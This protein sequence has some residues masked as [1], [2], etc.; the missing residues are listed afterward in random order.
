LQLIYEPF[1]LSGQWPTFQ[2]VNAVGWH[3]L[4]SPDG[5]PLEPRLVYYELSG[6]GLV[7]PPVQRDRTWELRD[8][9]VVSLSLLGLTYLDAASA[10]VGNCVNAVR[11]IGERAH[12]FRPASPT[13]PERLQI[14]SE[15]IRLTLR[16]EVG[17]R[18]LLR[19]A[20]LLQQD[21]SGVWTSFSGPDPGAGWSFTVD[22]D[23]AR[24]YRNVATAYDVLDVQH[25][26]RQA[27]APT[28]VQYGSLKAG[29]LEE[30]TMAVNG[31]RDPRV[32]ISYSHRDQEFVLA[33]MEELKRRGVRVW[34]DQ[35]E[36]VVGDSLVTRIGDA[37][38][39]GDFVVGVI[40]PHSVESSWCQKEL[41]L[42]VTR[43]INE[44]RVT[45][46]PIR[47][48]DV[49]MPSF[50]TDV[51]YAEGDSPAAITDELTRAIDTH[52]KRAG[53]E[54]ATALADAQADSE[55]VATSARPH[56]VPP[57]PRGDVLAL[58]DQIAQRIDEV[59]I[60]WDRCRNAGGGTDDLIAEQRRLR[61]LLERV[62][63]D[64][65]RALPLIGEIAAATW[66]E[67][68]RVRESASAEPDLRE[69]MRAVRTQ[70]ERGLPIV[71]RWRITA[72]P[73]EV[74][75]GG[76]DTNA[77]R[78]Q[79]ER[80]GESRAIVVYISRTAMASSNDHLSAD[81]V[82]AKTTRGRSVVTNLLS[83][84]DPPRE[85]MVSTEAVRWELP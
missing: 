58:L 54:V 25:E 47:L 26:L 41:A 76:R 51:L 34:I 9:T 57:G 2:H 77:Y 63:H 1:E 66:Q 21:A 28:P 72:G 40:S 59:L 78:L 27:Y 33:L 84:D 3:E 42:A 19:L 69:E 35:V 29:T 20:Y 38:Q 55:S 12:N 16:F 70:V 11:Y 52:L 75:S 71:A 13:A 46:L 48:G 73:K 49:T 61:T 83:V 24:R 4:K 56:A 64:V 43:G 5:D 44:K 31:D 7:R 82:A 62:P 37:I 65:Q 67:F 45:V 22:A 17:D 53:I 32:F 68:F 81:V 15:E 18:A 50:L 74:S 79:I 10:D 60:Q 80:D 6:S 36:L 85:V 39:Q 30:T 23:V 8:E 14:T